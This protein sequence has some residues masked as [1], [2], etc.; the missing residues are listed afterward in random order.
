MDAGA[1]LAWFE[2]DAPRRGLR[3]EYEAGALSVMAPRHLAAD[4]LALLARERG[5]GP[6]RLTAV[7]AELGRLGFELAD[8]PIT[9]LA[10]WLAKG[11]PADRA[12][13]PALATAHE[14]PLVTD[15]PELRRVAKTVLAAD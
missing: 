1:L 3:A 5:F 4:A 8:P 15:D 14:L 13:Y 11:L 12:A 6:D 9:E 10:R 7:A 2:P